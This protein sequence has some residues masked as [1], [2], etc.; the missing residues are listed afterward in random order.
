MQELYHAGAY[1]DQ[2]DMLE[3][4]LVEAKLELKAFNDG[5]SMKEGLKKF[6]TVGAVFDGKAR[7]IRDACFNVMI[8]I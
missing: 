5:S 1:F 2:V 7:F 3:G 8:N 4:D 6:K